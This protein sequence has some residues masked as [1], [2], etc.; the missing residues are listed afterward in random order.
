MLYNRG[1]VAQLPSV[2]L[3]TFLFDNP[4]TH[5]TEDTPLH[6]EARD[7]DRVITKARARILT[8]QFAHFLRRSHGIGS[9]GPGRDI[10]VCLSTGQSALP[11]LFWSVVA[12]EGIYSAASPAA[13]PGDIA[14]QIQDGPGRLLVCSE[15]LRALGLAAAA[16]AHLPQRNVLVLTSYPHIE[17]Y[18]AVDGA[19]RCGFDQRL[20]WPRLTDPTELDTRTVCIL[21]S[22]GTTGLPKGVRISHTNVVAEAVLPSLMAR[23]VFEKWAAEGRPLERRILGH[24]P[25]AHIAGVQGYFISSFYEG[26]CVY[27]MPRFD[28]ADFVTHCRRLRITHLLSVPPIFMAIA[29]HP[30]VKDALGHVRIAISG[31]APLGG[32]TQEAADS[33]LPDGTCVSQVWGLSETTGT[34]TYTPPNVKLGN[35]SLG[36]LLPNMTMRLVDDHDQDVKPGQ[37]GEAW[38]K[39]PLIT[40]GYHNRPEADKASFSEDGWFKTGDVLRVENNEL[41]IVDRKKEIIK[42]KG[43]QIAPAELEGILAAHPA[44]TDAA[45]VGALRDGN[46]LPRAHVVL[47]PGSSGRVTE[48]DLKEYVKARVSDHKQLRGGVVFVDA[49]PRSA[50]GKILRRRLRDG[51]GDAHGDADGDG[52]GNGNGHG[53]GHGDSGGKAKL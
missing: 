14:R 49:V 10:V 50:A 35:G 11:C 51:D 43:L 52:D 46:E 13:T 47:A 38:L 15:D 39:G 33:Q 24:L 7:P 29:K 32:E 22:S 36:F 17:L 25:A 12:A 27:W 1:N 31:A 30:A 9:A 6:A 34:V 42:Y 48:E 28:F 2:D 4:E 37:A 26:V 19:L 44:V 5:A 21:Y 20:A 41:F 16:K 40:K 3:L 45:V 18:G 23:P 53:H 8:Q